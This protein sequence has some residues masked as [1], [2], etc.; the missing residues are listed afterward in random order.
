MDKD[1][2]AALI[3]GIAALVGSVLGA[4]LTHIFT[5]RQYRKEQKEIL[6]EV[7]L[8][9]KFGALRKF[10]VLTKPYSDDG[11]DKIIVKENGQA[12]LNIDAAIQFNKRIHDFIYTED[13]VLI[14]RQIRQDVIPQVRGF[15]EKTIEEGGANL[16]NGRMAI[17]NHRA[18]QIEEG[19]NWIRHRAYEEA[20]LDELGQ[21][22]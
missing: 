15:I 10:L 8:E 21:D 7:I 1:V 14:S 20:G 18:K 9:N 22:S 16:A 17:T 6:R 4:I 2:L 19:L 5:I 11:K 13:G 3:G 12:Y